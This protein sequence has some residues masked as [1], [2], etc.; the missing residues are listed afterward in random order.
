MTSP[1][2]RWFR[3]HLL[4]AVLLML[5]AGGCLYLNVPLSLDSGKSRYQRGWPFT[6]CAGNSVTPI[7][8]LWKDDPDAGWVPDTSGPEPSGFNGEWFV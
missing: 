5:T 8:V 4:T 3:F 1:K 6:M 2:R 7:V